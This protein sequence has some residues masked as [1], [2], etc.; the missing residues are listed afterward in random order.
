MA[1]IIDKNIVK[2]LNK[3]DDTKAGIHLMIRLIYHITLIYFSY[4]F[5]SKENYIVSLLFAIPHWMVYSFSGY[6]GFSHELFHNSVFSNSKL[7]KVLYYIFMVLNWE[8]Y[9][10]F[11]LTHW[12]HHKITLDEKDPKSLFSDKINFI[13]L[14]QLL[15]FDFKGFYKKINYTIKNAFG[16]IP[17]SKAS[18]LFP[19]D[20]IEREELIVAARVVLLLHTLTAFIFAISGLWILI[21]LINL[22]PFIISFFNRFLGFAQHYGLESENHNDYLNNCRTVVLPKFWS[23]FYSN[24]NYHIEHHMYPFIP[25]YNIE[26]IHTE[27]K[28][29]TEYK[30]ISIGWVGLIKDLKKEGIF[31]LI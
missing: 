28:K 10:Y 12:M 14:I 5:F 3:K 26:K 31:K 23:F 22:S 15:T 7:N 27:L 25:Y 24:M 2:N 11:K 21:F 9:N 17:I 19:K 20:S 30:N 4:L 6:A 8:N 1:K 29:S 13:Y 16:I 18:H